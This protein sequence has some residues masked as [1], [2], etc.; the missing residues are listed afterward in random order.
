ME[1]YV[2]PALP[3]QEFR[4][5]EGTVIPYGE[6]WGMGSPPDDAYSVLT[7]AERFQPLH[8]VARA[9]IAYLEC[10]YDVTASE[11]PAYVADLPE[12]YVAATTAVRL[13][14]AGADSAPMTIAFTS[15]PGVVVRAGAVYV[16]PFPVCGCDACDDT[17][18][19]E[20]ERLESTVFGIVS[21]G[22]KEYLTGPRRKVFAYD[23]TVADG[24][25][26]GTQGT[27]AFSP[28]R[29]KTARATLRDRSGAWA[30][31]SFRES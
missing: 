18:E 7:H 29:L 15:H 14:P 25:S 16:E 31:W 19:S 20:A 5:A 12:N 21:G 22:L 1:P 10:A 6:R 30:P 8:D 27:H 11:D 3:A 9:L 17:A 4:D 28:E 2:R 23:L 13:T 24:G 26:S